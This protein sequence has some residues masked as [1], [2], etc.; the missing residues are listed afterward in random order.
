MARNAKTD[1]RH[2]Q[3]FRQWLFDYPVDENMDMMLAHATLA[4]PCSPMARFLDRLF[5]SGMTGRTN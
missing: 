4:R 5:Y 2:L 3:M 1:S